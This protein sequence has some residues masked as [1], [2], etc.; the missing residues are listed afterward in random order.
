MFVDDLSHQSHSHQTMVQVRKRSDNFLTEV[1][2]SRWF[3]NLFVVAAIFFFGAIY[4]VL[5]S[6]EVR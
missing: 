4:L 2:L 1:T 6:K 3:F 5:L